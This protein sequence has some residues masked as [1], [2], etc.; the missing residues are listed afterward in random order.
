MH[1]VIFQLGS[2]SFPAYGL[3]V[4]AG[5][6]AAIFYIFRK[7]AAAG[8]KKDDV[9]DVVFYS[10][11]SGMAGAK[12]FYAVTYWRE[13]GAGLAERLAYL[14]TNFRYGF[15]FYGGLL[16][17]LAG[18]FLSARKKLKDWR[19]AADVFAPAV[20]LGHAFGRIGCFLA[21][22]CH[23]SPTSC[24]LGV[25]FTDP[26]SEVAPAYLGVPLHPTQ[27]YEAAGNLVIF[28]FLNAALGRALKG[29]LPA[30]T[31][32]GL[33]A[34]LYSAQRFGLEF[35]RGDDRGAF[36]LGLSPAQLFSCAI[37]CAAA[38]YIGILKRNYEKKQDR[39]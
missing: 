22:C 7:A 20:A 2:F 32:P 8:L 29:R 14:L 12:L 31:V 13:F 28:A 11:L 5:Y 25:T 16:G 1:P 37:F 21:G 27:L 38:V 9:S 10:V 36:L 26:A 34:L 17:G 33:Y 3:L 24:A 6:L 39:L 19:R 23:G 35:L 4:A 30:G 18:F 15:V